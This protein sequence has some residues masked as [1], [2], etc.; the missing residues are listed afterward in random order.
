MRNALL[1]S[2]RQAGLKKTSG[3]YESVGGGH[4]KHNDSSGF[5]AVE[6]ASSGGRLGYLG[7]PFDQYDF[8]DDDG[9]L[10]LYA[11][12][13]VT[14]PNLFSCI[15]LDLCIVVGSDRLQ[16]VLWELPGSIS[17]RCPKL[18]ACQSPSAVY[19]SATWLMRQIGFNIVHYLPVRRLR[20]P[21]L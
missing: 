18:P 8:Y 3:Q 14:Q 16:I 19:S 6:S 21:L 2:V 15:T 20:R 13:Q 4:L 5:S 11:A 1:E 7:L 10:D 12:H 17:W 9:S